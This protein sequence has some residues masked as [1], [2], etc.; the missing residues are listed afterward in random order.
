MTY[1]L[2]Q[3]NRE[4]S[5]SETDPFTERRYRQFA[6]HLGAGYTGQVLDI[7]CN[8]GR[9]GQAFMASAPGARLDGVELVPD[10]IERIPAGVSARFTRDCSRTCRPTAARTTRS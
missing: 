5:V 6:R 4:Q 10:R 3:I 1:E 8:T 2:E 7:G 9:G